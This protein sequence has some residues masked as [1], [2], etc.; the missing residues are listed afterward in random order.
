VAPRPARHK[1]TAACLRVLTWC[2][3]SFPQGIY[4]NQSDMFALRGSCAGC[5]MFASAAGKFLYKAQ[6]KTTDQQGQWVI[7]SDKDPS[8]YMGSLFSSNLYADQAHP[9]DAKGDW[10]FDGGG[11]F[12]KYVNFLSCFLFGLTMVIVLY[13]CTRLVLRI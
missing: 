12:I 13:T 6:Q 3:I 4:K 11:G 9:V 1:R 10:K 7:D 8:G 5:S 2:S